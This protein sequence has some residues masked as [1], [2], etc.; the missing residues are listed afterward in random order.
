MESSWEDLEDQNDSLSFS[1]LSLEIFRQDLIKEISNQQNIYASMPLGIFSGFKSESEDAQPGLVA[2]LGYPSRK[3]GNKT[4]YQRHNLVYLDFQG[5]PIIEKPG[6]VLKFLSDHHSLDRIVPSGI[7]QN[8]T[9][10]IN[11][12]SESIKSWLQSFSAG[13][14]M[15]DLL[16]G[17]QG[18]D[19]AKRTSINDP[20]TLEQQYDPDNCDLILWFCIS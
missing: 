20:N 4:P 7:D 15:D 5:N 17:L 10:E 6:K 16:A 11:R 19:L 2:L 3:N 8:E 18:G 13:D 1:D 14:A 9:D 12:Y